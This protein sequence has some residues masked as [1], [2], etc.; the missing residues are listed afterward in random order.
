MQKKSWMSYL[1]IILLV[2]KVIQHITV[3]LAFL[4][5]SGDIQSMVAFD[6]KIFMV[7]GAIVAVF[8][9][10]ALYGMIKERKWSITLTVG[11]ALF[12]IIGEFVAQ[13]TLFIVITVSVL[14]AI[15][16]LGLCYHEYRELQT[17]YR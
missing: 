9:M 14:V 2:E 8:F 7:S 6:Y 13:G 5:N 10:V 17:D 12:D 4:Y 3:T 11:L 1:L 15:V 16:L